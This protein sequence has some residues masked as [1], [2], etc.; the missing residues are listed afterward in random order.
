MQSPPT[1][2]SKRSESIIR[3][4]EIGQYVFCH[5]A[6]WLGTVKGYRPVNETVLHAGTQVHLQHGRAV[7]TSQRWSQIGYSLLVVG[8]LLGAIALCGVL[9]G[10]L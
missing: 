9:G 6:W 10:K 1:F 8:G 4:S 7:A 5:R 2:I 3:A